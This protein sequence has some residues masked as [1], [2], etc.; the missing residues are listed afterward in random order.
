MQI[1]ACGFGCGGS[2]IR[3]FLCECFVSQAEGDTVLLCL[4]EAGSEDVGEQWRR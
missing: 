2:E 4:R 1:P 3:E